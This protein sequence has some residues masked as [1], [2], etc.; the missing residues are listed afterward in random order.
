MRAIGRI[1]W[2][3]GGMLKRPLDELQPP[4]QALLLRHLDLARLQQLHAPDALAQRQRRGRARGWHQQTLRVQLQVAGTVALAVVLV[5]RLGTGSSGGSAAAG[6]SLAQPEGARI[7][8]IAASDKAISIWV[9]RT[10]SLVR[11]PS[12]A[13]S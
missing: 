11:F 9:A 5:Q 12:P 7:A 8:G 6:L 1:D 10:R 13:A 4:L 3:L 2:A